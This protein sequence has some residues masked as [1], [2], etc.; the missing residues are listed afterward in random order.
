VVDRVLDVE[1]PLLLALLP[2]LVLFV[3]VVAVVVDDDDDGRG[4]FV[5]LFVDE[6]DVD[7]VV[8]VGVVVV[9]VVDDARPVVDLVFGVA[10]DDVDGA[11]VDE[12][13]DRAVGVRGDAAA[14]VFCLVNAKEVRKVNQQ[15]KNAQRNTFS[16]P[17]L[18]DDA[19]VDDR[20]A[21][22]E[23]VPLMGTLR[24]ATGV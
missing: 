12:E 11:V 5:A 6:E 21:A 14:G 1:A 3:V 22:T 15:R 17:L 10:V 19:V 13:D 7:V 2:L 9:E 20:Y 18:D 16:L 24:V 4:R 8:G 23:G